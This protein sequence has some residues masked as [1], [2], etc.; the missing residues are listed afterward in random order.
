[1]TDDTLKTPG[2]PGGLSATT[3][4][5]PKTDPKAPGTSPETSPETPPPAKPGK[6]K[7]QKGF[8]RRHKI[9]IAIAVL[10]ALIAGTAGGY[11][12]WINHQLSAIP[13]VDAGIQVDPAK[14]GNGQNNQDLNILLLGAD[15]GGDKQT[16]ADD[17]KDGTWT[18]F[19]HRSDTIMIAHIP[20]NRDSVQVISIPRDTWVPIDG[21]PYTDGHGKING[22]FAFGGP[23][24]AVKTVQQ[25]T[26]MNIDHVAIIDWV[27]FKDLT[28]ALGG[29]RVYIPETFYDDSQRITWH[30]GWQ[31][32]EGQEALAYVR[33]R[34][35]LTNGDFG[36]IERQ[37]NFMRA[38]MQKLLSSM[39]GVGAIS[40]INHL[41][42]TLKNYLTIDKTWE[43]DE[44]KN[45]AL[46]LSGIHT[47][48]VQFF[49]APLGSYGT[50]SDGQSIVELDAKKSRQLFTWVDAD[51]VQRYVDLYPKQGLNGNQ[52]I[53]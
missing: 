3:V 9:L 32:L 23:S 52:H 47:D 14:E 4:E 17:L 39:H 49:T 13:R 1:M 10:L 27:G 2:A 16:V 19:A 35:G 28:T 51:N 8:I 30:Q 15:N 24:L 5:P 18:P 46:S 38:T 26:G 42:S 20:A 36:R 41:L 6:R 45:L 11:Y 31:T 50:S 37:Q 25:L 29:V 33:T 7:K 40:V 22:A 34:H 48:N 21:Y 43:N 53:D 44:L 12:W